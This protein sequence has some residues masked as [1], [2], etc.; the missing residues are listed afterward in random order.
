MVGGADDLGA[1]GNSV[2]AVISGTAFLWQAVINIVIAK[3]GIKNFVPLMISGMN[4]LT[5]LFSKLKILI[6]KWS[7]GTRV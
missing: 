6:V 2:L 3:Y 5:E 7:H 4:D 1:D